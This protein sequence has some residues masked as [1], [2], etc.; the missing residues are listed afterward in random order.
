MIRP[1]IAP[2]SIGIIV[3]CVAVFLAELAGYKQ[4]IVQGGQLVG[5]LQ[6]GA[7]FGPLVQAGQWWRVLTT[8]FEHGGPIHLLFNMSVVWTLGQVLERSIGS[9]RFALVSLITALGSSALALIFSFDVPTVGA[10][11]MILGWAGVMLPIATKQGRQSLGIWLVQIVVISL[12]PGVSWQGHLG[13]FLAGLPVGFALKGGA[14][15]F[16]WAAPLILFAVAVI[17]VLAGSGRLV[18]PG[19]P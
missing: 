16:R 1:P 4:A 6:Y 8:V 10:S 11:G 19:F 12:L 2:V 3:A 15:R 13:G 14:P 18:P 9:W 17:T 5:Y 7:L